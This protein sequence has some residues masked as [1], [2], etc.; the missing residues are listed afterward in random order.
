MRRRE[1]ITLTGGAAVLWPLAAQALDPSSRPLIAVLNLGSESS[2][3][4]RVRTFI[5]AMQSLGYVDGRNYDLAV[6][7][8]DGQLEQLSALADELARLKPI[9]FVAGSTPTTLAARQASGTIPIVSVGVVDP[10]GLGLAAN[11]ARPGGQVTGTLTS[12]EGLPGKQ[13]ALAAEV[14]SSATR[15]GLLVNPNNKGHKVQ[16]QSA[17]TTAASLSRLLVFADAG[18]PDELDG[19]FKFLLRERV[20]LVLVLSDPFFYKEAKRIAVL[21]ANQRLPTMYAFREHVEA[22]GLM[23]Y[24]ISLNANWNRAAYFADKILKGAKPGDIP[25]E[26]PTKLELVINLRAAKAIGITI[27]ESF[28]LRA[29]EVIE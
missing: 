14:I 10:V 4:P 5:Q 26:L 27:P 19:A 21:A 2:V 1:F 17:E 13:L 11:E 12:V 20:D 18:T 16:R 22:G 9:L 24:G 25:I 3:S 8:A 29:D 23:S 28:L 15:F 6:R 7:Y